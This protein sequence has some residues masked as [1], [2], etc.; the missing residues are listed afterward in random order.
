MIA[1][2]LAL[3]SLCL[4]VA[5]LLAPRPALA[6]ATVASYD[7][8]CT[9]FTA[10]G[11]STSPYAV[12]YVYNEQT[13]QEYWTVVPVVGGAFAGTVT[14]PVASPGT[15]F[16]LYAWGS[17]TN[18]WEDWDS[19]DYFYEERLGCTVTDVPALDLAGLGLMTTLL[20]LA[21]WVAVRRGAA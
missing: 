10:Q 9:S 15:V 7:F 20:G 13:G 12:I 16:E 6:S 17:P 4:V 18:D 3:V 2:R 21:G 19:E 1:R 14:F 8:T 5:V 11:T